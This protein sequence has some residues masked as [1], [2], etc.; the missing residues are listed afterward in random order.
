MIAA[1]R[2]Q[3]AAAYLDWARRERL[4][5][6]RVLLMAKH[7]FPLSPDAGRAALP[8][9]L[10]LAKERGIA[11]EVVALADTAEYQLDYEAY[12]RDVGRII[13][14]RGNAFL[15]IANEPG[16]AT[17]D[18]RVHDPAFVKGL[19]DLVPEPVVVA[20]GSV[21]YGE[22]YAAADYATFH[23]PRGKKEWEHVLALSAG[24]RRVAELKKPTISD[25][26]IG[27][28]P[29]YQPGRRDNEPSR[30]AAA[31]ALTRLAGME[32]TFHYESGLQAKI[33]Q[34]REATCL[35]A[36][37]SGAAL[38]DGIPLDGAFVAGTAVRQIVEQHSA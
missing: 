6:V 12:I 15:E 17:Q 23:F 14:E 29:P 38:L 2:E 5:V 7:L 25:E 33:A 20:L 27:A 9:L 35:A 10:D 1:G 30:F 24:A 22:G 4:T 21:E 19:A 28:G 11:V 8:R 16:H 26:P 3:E 32:A 37:Q 36:W 31:A 13:F 18:K 34:G